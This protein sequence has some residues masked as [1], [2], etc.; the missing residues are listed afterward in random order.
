MKHPPLK[1]LGYVAQHFTWML[2][3]PLNRGQAGRTIARYL[4]WQLGSRLLGQP[5][6]Y[7]FV[8]DLKV[9][10]GTGMWGATGI[11]Y[12]GLEEYSDMA[13]CAHLLRVGDLFVDVGACFGSYSLLASG[14]AGARSLAFEP[15]PVTAA[16]FA[17]NMHLNRLD[18][19]VTLRT[20]AVGARAGSALMTSE[21]NAANY[22]VSAEGGAGKDARVS[23]PLTTLDMEMGGAEPALIKI[24]VEGY[25][26]DVLDGA[27]VTLSRASLLAVIM[28][29]VGLGRRY[30]AASRQHQ[31]MCD[32][33]FSSYS[34][35][36]EQRQLVDLQGAPN[37]SGLNTLYIRDVAR[38]RTR[39]ATATPFQVR[40]RSI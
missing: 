37:P 40:G 19:L 15:N 17:D 12:F 18:D 38:A 33:G 27:D 6:V 11:I 14:V 21:L 16:R 22:V 29:D 8:N 28:E 26:Q 35:V 20:A 13:F 34:Y 2:R 30:H 9:Q 39:L 3:H 36:P 7:P 10:I 25:E 32:L 4:G 31:R 23:V 5:V 1:T 24:D